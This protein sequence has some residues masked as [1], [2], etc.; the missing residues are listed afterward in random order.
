M[1]ARPSGSPLRAGVLG[2]GPRRAADPLDGLLAAVLTVSL[3]DAGDEAVL[4]VLESTPDGGER[5]DLLL[6]HGI[7]PALAAAYA[8]LD[9]AL[10]RQ[11]RH[12]PSAALDGVVDG[13]VERTAARVTR[14]VVVP[15]QRVG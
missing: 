7:T 12:D 9:A 6:R 5:V 4:G 10:V 8:G 2:G 11:A 13:V 3:A 1:T 14:E 15:D